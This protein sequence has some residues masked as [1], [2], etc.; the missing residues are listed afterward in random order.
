MP[1]SVDPA[2]ARWLTERPVQLRGHALARWLLRCL[3]WR[4]VWDGLPARQ[5]VLVAY[6]HTSNWDFV[7]GLL[8]KWALG[9]PAAFWIKDSVCRIPLLGAWIRWV[10]G[11]PVDRSG[12]LGIAKAMSERFRAAC[13]QDAFL[14]L[15][16]APEGTRGWVPHWRS[17]F[18]PVALAA[19]V[20]VGLVFFDYQR[21]RVG[22]DRFM[23]LSGDRPADLALIAGYYRDH[24]RACRPENAGLIQFKE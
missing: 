20:P 5:G 21:R 22:V 12:A 4:L 9:L 16:V 1:S 8:A 10:G 24:A 11:I 23:M 7:V 2:G 15:A 19:G 17:G 14:W 6:P 18:Y 3:G 13:E